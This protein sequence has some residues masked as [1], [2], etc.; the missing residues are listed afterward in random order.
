MGTAFAVFPDGRNDALKLRGRVTLWMGLVILV[1]ALNTGQSLFALHE[2]NE[3]DEIIAQDYEI[4]IHVR[5]LRAALFSYHDY[6]LVSSITKSTLDVRKRD[7]SLAELETA[8]SSGLKP[9]IR[10]AFEREFESIRANVQNLVKQARESADGD[11]APFL[12]ASYRE[13]FGRTIGELDRLVRDSADLVENERE[14]DQRFYRR[15]LIL[16]FVVFAA[17]LLL[18]LAGMF[19]FRRRVLSPVQKLLD[20]AKGVSRGD[21]SARNRIEQGDEIGEMARTLDRMA[22]EL[23]LRR[24]ERIQFVG[25]IA[26]D[27]KN[28]LTAIGLNCELALRRQ[29]KSAAL[30]TTIREQARRLER[31]SED[32]LQAAKEGKPSWGIRPSRVD[33][34]EAMLRA[35]ESAKAG[36]PDR[37]IRVSGSTEPL[38]VEFDEDRLQQVAVNLLSNALKYSPAESEVEVAVGEEGPSCFFEVRDRGLGIPDSEKDA[39]FRPFE[40][41]EAGRK[42]ASGAGLGLAIVLDIVRSHGGSIR[43]LDRAGGGSVFRVE[44]PRAG[45]PALKER[46]PRAG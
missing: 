9:G 28:P 15:N 27:F 13:L 14:R 10:P 32:L 26:H 25:A 42:A 19:H 1:L 37:A 29:E 12:D 20:W 41:T 18:L 33:L 16:T 40:R 34:R 4:A 39:V 2:L 5:R 30:L 45:A 35:I 17:S 24:K 46:L 6:G 7:E 38:E 36:A 21:Y 43:V 22:A 31:L 44:L 8:L 11:R 23:E 3:T